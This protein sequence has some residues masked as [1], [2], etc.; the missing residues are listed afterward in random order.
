MSPQSKDIV[1]YFQVH[2]PYRIKPYSIFEITHDH[3]YFND[4]DQTN[5]HI[6]EKVA[7]KSYRPMNKLILKLLKDQPKFRVTFSLSGVFLE[8]ALDWA[9]DLIYDFRQMVATGKVEL[10]AETYYH[11][12]AFFYNRDEF[13]AQI[14]K[15]SALIEELFGVT[16]KA[17]RGT[18]LSYSNS[19]GQWA[20]EHGFRAILAEGWEKNLDWR[21]PN[22]VYK[23]PGTDTALLMRN[24][25][26]SDDIAF[27]FSNTSWRD[28]PLT[29]RKFTDWADRSLT[30]RDVLNLFMDYETF[31]EHHWEETG[32]FKFFNNFINEWSTLPSHGFLTVSEAVEKY[33]AVDEINVPDATSWADANRD[34]SAWLGNSMQQQA[35][36]ALYEQADA[37]HASNDYKLQD[38]WRKLQTSDNLYY[39]FTSKDVNDRKVH[40]YF[41]PHA[42]PYD[43][44]IYYMNAVRDI[45]A[46][47]RHYG[48]N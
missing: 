15:H 6:F 5:Q 23:T 21:S 28:F 27:R 33:P 40:D 26:L 10:L 25:K 48:E 45:N 1:F 36:A 9:P 37:V 32:I 39:L 20:N 4:Q 30:N 34:L 29:S 22:Y 14:V 42:S 44:F 43:A 38:D 16:P 18:E 31:G 2:Q 3:D 13:E 41:S 7:N 8:Q 24:Y 46:R 11:S 35:G 17:F 12:L 19:L 47:L